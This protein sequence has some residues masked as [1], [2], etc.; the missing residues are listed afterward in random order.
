MDLTIKSEINIILNLN[1]SD[2]I[3]AR[4]EVMDIAIQSINTR[5]KKQGKQDWSISVINAERKKWTIIYKSGFRPY[6]QAVISYL[7]KKID[8]YNRKLKLIS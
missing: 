4:R 1:V 6:C 8:K 7:D 2:L 3:K 5:C